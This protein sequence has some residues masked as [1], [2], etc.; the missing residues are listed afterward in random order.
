MSV[1]VCLFISVYQFIFV[2]VFFSFS[3]PMPVCQP[4]VSLT[5]NLY[6]SAYQS[7]SNLSV[8]LYFCICLSVCLSVAISF[9]RLSTIISRNSSL[10]LQISHHTSHSW[11]LEYHAIR[12]LHLSKLALLC[13][14]S[15]LSCA[16]DILKLS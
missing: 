7:I 11:A 3:L 8:C 15:W 5:V 6:V 9:F 1:S 14:P 16:C 4:T 13:H 12:V 10:E 2:P